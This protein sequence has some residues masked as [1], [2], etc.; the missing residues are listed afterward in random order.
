MKSRPYIQ[1]LVKGLTRCKKPKPL[2]GGLGKEVRQRFKSLKGKLSPII[3]RKPCKIT[4][5]LIEQAT[6]YYHYYNLQLSSS[7]NLGIN[8]GPI[9]KFV[10]RYPIGVINLL[11]SLQTLGTEIKTRRIG[12]K[13]VK[14]GM[15]NQRL[16]KAIDWNPVFTQDMAS[17]Q[18]TIR[19]RLFS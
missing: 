11:I 7:G 19:R 14:L 5:N 2:P 18:N 8:L 13:R 17:I 1:K 6:S 16:I 9:L 4:D 15:I 3:G 12:G 10:P